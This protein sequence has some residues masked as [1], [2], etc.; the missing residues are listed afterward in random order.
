[1]GSNAFRPFAS[2]Y[3]DNLPKRGDGRGLG[4]T[5]RQHGK[6]VGQRC[7]DVVNGKPTIVERRMRPTG[8]AD[9][10]VAE[11]SVTVDVTATEAAE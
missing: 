8:N 4:K 9:E 1:M 11:L 3:T 10:H 5:I 6:W 2:D 7:Q